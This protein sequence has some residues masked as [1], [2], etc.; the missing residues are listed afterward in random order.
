M[1][2]GISISSINQIKEL[3]EEKRYAEALEI[4]DTQD[5]DKSINPQFLRISGEIFRK[6]KRYYD[7]RRILLKAHQM[8]PQ[9]TRII[10]ELIQLYLELGY[11]SLANKYYEEYNFYVG[12]EDTQKEFVEYIVKKANGAD[13]KELASILIPILERM[14]EDHWNY[15]AVLLY[16]KL[17]RKDKAL[18][19]SRFI[20]ENFKNSNY[21]ERVIA[22]IDDELNVDEEFYIYPKEEQEEDIDTFGDL[23]DLEKGILEK[24]FLTMYPPEARIMVEVEDK[25]GIDVKPVK[26]KKPKKKKLKKSKKEADL[27]END[28]KNSL[29]GEVVEDKVQEQTDKAET[30]L[31]SKTETTADTLASDSDNEKDKAVSESKDN[32]VTKSDSSDED[33]KVDKETAIN[34]TE[35]K[36]QSDNDVDKSVSETGET[37]SDTEGVSENDGS[38]QNVDSNEHVDEPAEES[39]SEE[40]LI[41]KKREEALEKLLSK[42]FD[43][44]KI[45]E[46]AKQI[47]DSVRGIDTSKAKS[48]VKNVTSLVTDNMKKATDVL[49]EAVGTKSVMEEM[50]EQDDQLDSEAFVDGIIEDVLEPPKQT[51]G[52]VVMNEELDSLV[53]D[54]IEAMSADE[55]A[56]IEF[57]KEEQER[58]EL[59]ALEASVKLEEEK[60]AK[61]KRSK[62]E[63]KA[64]GEEPSSYSEL[65]NK[66]I[67]EYVTE[68]TVADSLGFISVVHSDVDEVM[69]ENIPDTAQMLR[70]MIGNKEFYKNENSLGFES[71]ES[72][73]NHGFEIESYDSSSNTQTENFIYVRQ[74]YNSD[75]YK[76]EDI[77]VEEP[78]VSF[79]ELVPDEIVPMVDYVQSEE[80]T[81]GSRKIEESVISIVDENFEEFE[82]HL[83][84]NDDYLD[85]TSVDHNETE[86]ILSEEAHANISDI[87]NSVTEDAEP[88]DDKMDSSE[89]GFGIAEDAEPA[90]EEMNLSE[91]N[92]GIAEATE[93]VDDVLD[94]ASESIDERA[95]S[96]AGV[97]V[98]YEEEQHV[99][100]DN[101]EDSD[102]EYVEAPIFGEQLSFNMETPVE[103]ARK[104]RIVLRSR[105]IISESMEKKLL[106]L[107]E[108]K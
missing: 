5:L 2:K 40:E 44:E 48:Q 80:W 105:I 96:F 68:E 97:A 88:V 38:T 26:E 60:R 7:S 84:S 89:E 72:Y 57:R 39:I 99:T 52:Q 82:N 93:S 22:Y 59:E 18:D 103:K 101:M 12:Q 45:K 50:I 55:I 95:D 17:E 32:S 13:I 70:Q 108:T 53:P 74:N 79:D 43:A 62:T 36:N 63:D 8:S 94:S 41:K 9:G 11:F 75:V 54:S 15:E 3:A 64:D 92:F 104:E 47:A 25:E 1:S 86:Y 102:K 49:S 106:A 100:N 83:N 42:R 87:E 20:L 98:T 14:P 27:P 28:E 6:N 107:K 10:S 46:S 71:K 69:E 4:L 91:E 67:E 21:T 19:E 61:K 30:Q 23:L 77:Y 90:D 73:Y 24:D 56:D 31:S 58:L 33:V 16:D 35:L 37:E 85:D 51:V 81:H 76:V 65:K 78:I 34:E 66:Y 29:D